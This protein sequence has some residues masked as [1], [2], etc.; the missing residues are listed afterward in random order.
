VIRS[1]KSGSQDPTGS[2]TA[3]ASSTTTSISISASSTNIVKSSY[4]P[5]TTTS[6][7][8]TSTDPSSTSKA[9][10]SVVKSSHRTAIIS[11][12]VG[13]IVLLVIAAVCLCWYRRKPVKLGLK[14]KGA[15]LGLIESTGLVKEGT[16]TPRIEIPPSD[17]QYIQSSIPSFIDIRRES[18]TISS[19]RAVPSSMSLTMQAKRVQSLA[20]V[21]EY[22]NIG[23]AEG[24]FQDHPSAQPTTRASTPNSLDV[25]LSASLSALD[26]LQKGIRTLRTSNHGGKPG[27]L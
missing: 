22:K 25:N 7:E 4:S 17:M 10:L 19:L 9:D 26:R 18:T 20:Q 14:K 16:E 13:G 5:T 6:T 24:P 11:G 1:S 3:T 27:F 23:K 8:T 15:D 12:T 21:E 2:S